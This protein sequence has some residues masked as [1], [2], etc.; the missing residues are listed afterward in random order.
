ML[1]GFAADLAVPDP[2]R[3]HPV[4]LFGGFAQRLEALVYADRRRRGVL[5]V[6]VSTGTATGLAVAGTRLAGDRVGPRALLTVAATWTVLG[7]ASLHRV[8]GRLARALQDDDLGTARALLP[9]LCGRD[10]DTLDA[11]G[12]ARAGVESVAEN[13]S[14]A[15]VAPLLAGA[16]AGVPGLVAYRAV[17]TLDAMVGHRSLR[18]ARFGWAAARLDDLANLVPAR[19]TG[20]LAVACAPRVGGS[21]AA[22]YAVMRRDGGAHP[23]PNAG[24]CEAA[25]A[26]ALGL[27]LGGENAYG[28]RVER[29]GVLGD[30]RAPAAEDVRRAVTLARAVG[31]VAAVLTAGTA[32]L[33]ERSVR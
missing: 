2:R 7:G 9:S 22:A 14:D 32:V 19:V 16:V 12:L 10:P 17:N 4:A 8:A 27:R 29:R 26:G 5:L 31:M 20:L 23:S 1:A 15:V 13:T 33:R 28:G 30:G 3:A 18:Y 6:A 24:R 11:G 21:P 25:F